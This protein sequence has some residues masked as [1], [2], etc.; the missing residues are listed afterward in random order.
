MDFEYWGLPRFRQSHGNPGDTAQLLYIL[1]SAE[2]YDGKRDDPQ[3]LFDVFFKSC[4]NLFC[5]CL[6]IRYIIDFVMPKNFQNSA[7]LVVGMLMSPL[8]CINSYNALN[9]NTSK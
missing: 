2:Q 7:T 9:S 6:I 3:N 1:K 8:N 5:M 4:P